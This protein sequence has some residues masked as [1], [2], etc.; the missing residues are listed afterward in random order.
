[1]PTIASKRRSSF[2]MDWI[3]CGSELIAPERS[4]Y[5]NERHILHHWHCPKCDCSFE[6]ISP[7]DTKSIEDIMTRI[8]S[9]VTRGDV[10]PSRLVAQGS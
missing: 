6:V 2:G 5:W 1:M 9:I 3:Q 4:E 8:E 7:A 10:Y